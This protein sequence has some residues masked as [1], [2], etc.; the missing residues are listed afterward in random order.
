MHRFRY[1]SLVFVM[2]LG[3]CFHGAKATPDAAAEKTEN[4]TPER[5]EEEAVVQYAR[6]QTP[7][8]EARRSHGAFAVP[9]ELR[10]RVDFWKDIF[11]RYDSKQVV[12]HH[13]EF[14]QIVFGV[15]DLR[16]ESE[17]MGPIE[18]AR[19]KDAVED[20]TVAAVKA[21]LEPLARGADASTEFQR[22]IVRIMQA[23]PGG[24]AKYRRALDE[25]L[26]RTQ[27]GIRDRYVEAIRRSR[28]YLP[29][30]EHIFVNEFG[31]PKELTRLP[32][33]ESSFDYTAYSSVGAAGIW[34]FMPRTA[35]A[36]SMKV[37]R[38]VD[39]RRDP[40][41]ATRAAAEYLRSA[42]RSLGSWSLAITSYNHGVGGVR[43]KIRKAGSDDIVTLIEHP[44]ERYFGFASSNF[45]PEFLAAVEIYDNWR[46]YFPEVNEEPPLRLI[47]V[48]L[49]APASPQY[50]VSQL[51]IPLDDL[52]EA[53]YA[54]LDP[55]W[56]GSAKIPAGYTLR[57]P[58]HYN[59][60]IDR[61]QKGVHGAG[62]GEVIPVLYTPSARQGS[63]KS[64][65]VRRTE[66]A[67]K[68]SYV[69]KRGDTLSVVAKKT[70]SSVESLK[71]AN[72]LKGSSVMVGQ[73]LIVP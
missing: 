31:L 64:A 23:V 71:R 28:R 30:M 18:F 26:V 53:N 19:H 2:L 20:R 39:E 41:K 7:P 57:I 55:I 69:V 45:F 34:Q 63:S 52:K 12:V 51:D 37:G 32:F 21:E 66:P 42:Q 35:R 44:T 17:A 36:H 6:M 65:A 54:L 67:T 10:P 50:V 3:S 27:T 56:R 1:I 13:R 40:L 16:A 9:E 43:S 14:P 48:H 8:A 49:P 68:R 59:D 61:L 47:S 24:A 62:D 58:A 38:Y 46:Q 5:V 25:D 70:G 4:P 60:R 11:A 72:R 15:I 73:R 22:K 29:M 33:V